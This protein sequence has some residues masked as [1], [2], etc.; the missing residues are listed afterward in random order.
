[1]ARRKKT[2]VA[3]ALDTE[4]VTSTNP[5]LDRLIK[6]IGTHECMDKATMFSMFHDVDDLYGRAFRRLAAHSHYLDLAIA[7]RMAEVAGGL[8]HGRV[9]H[10]LPHS[11]RE[12]AVWGRHKQFLLFTMSTLGRRQ[13]D[14]NLTADQFAQQV[15][16]LQVV[17]SIKLQLLKDY[18]VQGQR[19]LQ[20][21]DEL[22]QRMTRGVPDSSNDE[23]LEELREIA[24]ALATPEEYVPAL[25]RL[26]SD[27]VQRIE[28]IHER[29]F[30]HHLR[31]LIKVA[32]SLTLDP[33]QILDN[34]QAGSF[35]LMRAIRDY[36]P[37]FNFIGYA[38][39]WIR[40]AVLGVVRTYTSNIRIPGNVLQEYNN[41][42]RTRQRLPVGASLDDVAAAAG[43]DVKRAHRVYELAALS[44]TYSLDRS[45]VNNAD[46]PHTKGAIMLSDTLADPD[47][48]SDTVD[49][50][51]Q[52]VLRYMQHLNERERWV[53]C[54]Y[55]GLYD[56]LP[57]TTADTRVAREGAERERL[58]QA[59]I[60]AL[61][62]RH[63]SL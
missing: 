42:E 31:L 45:L 36:V 49:T 16:G 37:P 38:S 1:M 57:D 11:G 3:E 62:R 44:H 14:A 29:I 60:A 27:T 26:L 63:T 20:V 6:E 7:N 50:P 51:A 34:F 18:I 58:R 41:L 2:A 48:T 35:G 22:A 15:S 46:S 33:D 52:Q 61:A 55:F 56:Y 47:A 23:Q 59:L 5:I 17:G 8:T 32:N 39:Q 40:Q 9:I 21:S 13:L 24:A 53:V 54:G 4:S 12:D 28:A 10:S 25:T 30:N 43:V 19:Y